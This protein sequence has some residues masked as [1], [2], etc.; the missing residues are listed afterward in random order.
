[1]SRRSAEANCLLDETA[2]DVKHLMSL[3]EEELDQALRQVQEEGTELARRR[4][5]KQVLATRKLND[6]LRTSSHHGSG[7]PAVVQRQP[8]LTPHR[9]D[10][11]TRFSPCVRHTAHAH[12]LGIF[13]PWGWPRCPTAGRSLIRL[14][15][16]SRSTNTWGLRQNF[17]LSLG[18]FKT[19]PHSHQAG[20]L[21]LQ[22]P[23][24]TL[25]ALENLCKI[26][27]I[28]WFT[29][30]AHRCRDSLLVRTISGKVVQS[31]SVDNE[32]CSLSQIIAHLIGLRYLSV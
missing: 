5:A 25:S 24:C 28:F 29:N 1:M 7:R 2:R 18:H 30:G 13:G 26:L 10:T 20:R 16:R 27:Q 3:C 31:A 32:L 23:I 19:W 9:V 11:H 15:G 14:R 4:K 6:E 8:A 12:R 21:C 22:H 17:R